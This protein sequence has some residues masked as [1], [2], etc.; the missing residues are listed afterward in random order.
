[1]IAQLFPILCGLAAVCFSACIKRPAQ[2]AF[3]VAGMALVLLLTLPLAGRAPLWSG[4]NP[5]EVAMVIAVFAFTILQHHAWRQLALLMGGLVAGFWM[6]SLLRLGMPVSVASGVVLAVGLGTLAA[7]LK[8]QV[9]IDDDVLDEG[10]V[11]VLVLAL[12]LAL[13]PAVLQ[14][15][16]AAGSLQAL[17]QQRLDAGLEPAV[18][19][20]VLVATVL[21]LLFTL[22]RLRK[23][24]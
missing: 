11:G 6:N 3:F 1:M 2:A 16:Q 17:D 8:R 14:G 7:S 18:L 13:V 10:L 15:W 19:A 21:G 4:A 23:M 5:Q 22:Y 12:L 24:K 20:P 9:F